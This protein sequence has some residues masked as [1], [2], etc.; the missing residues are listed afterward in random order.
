MEAS[1]LQDQ[2][3]QQCHIDVNKNCDKYFI[4]RTNTLLAESRISLH[5]WLMA[6]YLLNTDLKGVSSYKL[7]RDL[8][9][10]QKTAW[11]LGHRI[12]KAFDEQSD[13]RFLI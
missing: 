8:G 4:I 12:K 9:V 11:F 6:V 2:N 1:G 10:T 5:K 7:R 3:I 13:N